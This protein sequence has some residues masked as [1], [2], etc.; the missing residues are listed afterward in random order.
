MVDKYR[1]YSDPA[2]AWLQVPYKEVI[3]S[4]VQ[5]SQ[6][7]YVDQRRQFVYLEEDCDATAFIAYKGYKNMCFIDMKDY[8]Y[9][10]NPIRLM[11]S[12]IN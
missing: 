2:H 12:F 3:D 5:F 1:W 9:E 7:S 8:D 4:G 6:F 10:T 11:E